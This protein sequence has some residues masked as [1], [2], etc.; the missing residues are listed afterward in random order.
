MFLDTDNENECY[1][2][3]ACFDVCPKGAIDIVNH[4]DTFLYPRINHTKCVSCGLCR[5]A[6]PKSRPSVS[7][8][9]LDAFSGKI[10][11]KEAFDRSSSGGAFEAIIRAVLEEL[12]ENK[13]L[14][15]AGV[16][17]NEKFR[18][19]HIL[20]EI[21][22]IDE[23]HPFN[24]SKYVQS[25]PS[26]VYKQIR[27][28]L[29]ESSNFVI[30]SGTPCQVD[31]LYSFLG[32]SKSDSL[33]TIDLVCKGAPSQIFFDKY[34]EELE[35][36]NDSSLHEYNFR[37]KEILDNGT[38][39]TRS[40]KYTFEN[41]VSKKVTRFNDPF[42]KIFYEKAY[43]TRSSCLECEYK[44]PARIADFTIGDSWGIEKKY[45]EIT[46]ITGVSLVTVNTS[47]AQKYSANMKKHM[48]VYDTDYEFL[49][50]NNAALRGG[51]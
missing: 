51:G 3:F 50:E 13:R 37:N 2:C 16:I 4:N 42:L 28:L 45:T 18:V 21:R 43:H 38:L 31:A 40:A 10:R 29:N 6:C 25:N 27:N 49:I 1:G 23:I 20:K 33:L 30:F 47:M 17:W 5:K 7:R 8:F 41:G 26:G 48:M 32:D 35:T 44:K 11:D 15:V 22:S 12:R 39:Y 19:V 36:Q 24:K 9:P 34:R 14:W 46:A